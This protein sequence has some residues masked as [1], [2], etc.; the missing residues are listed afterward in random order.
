M[1]SAFVALF[2]VLS[3][4]AR[5][6]QGYVLDQSCSDGRPYGADIFHGLNRAMDEGKREMNLAI[7][8][9]DEIRLDPLD[10][11]RER[12]FNTPVEN[13]GQAQ[14]RAQP[15]HAL[16]LNDANTST[17]Q[18]Y[19]RRFGIDC[20]GPGLHNLPRPQLPTAFESTS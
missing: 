13:L 12:M 8:D 19:I 11:T 3:T 5:L 7:E 10:N 4:L 18:R 20:L 1:A 9:L 2:I 17:W 14:G 16:D 6:S 15:A